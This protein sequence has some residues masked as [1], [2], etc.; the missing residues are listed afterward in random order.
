MKL[1]TLNYS[2]TNFVMI[3]NFEVAL[4]DSLTQNGWQKTHTGNDLI[5]K[6][7]MH[8]STLVE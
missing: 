1:T 2:I 8:S 5:S 4:V 6:E 3:T 7:I